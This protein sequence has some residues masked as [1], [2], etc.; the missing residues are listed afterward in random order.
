MKEVLL[1]A[2]HIKTVIIC[3]LSALVAV[4]FAF[5]FVPQLI[6][7][8]EYV[9]I[10][11]TALG[12]PG[13]EN[14]EGSASVYIF[15]IF[16]DNQPIDLEAVPLGEGWMYEDIY[17]G[18]LLAY[19]Q[20]SVLELLLPPGNLSIEFHQHA[21]SGWVRIEGAGDSLEYDLFSLEP[22]SLTHA[23]T[24]LEVTYSH[25]AVLLI[26]VIAYIAALV[27][28]LSIRHLPARANILT[29]I[30]SVFLIIVFV[31]AANP[32]P[33]VFANDE[34]LLNAVNSRNLGTTVSF[35][36]TEHFHTEGITVTITTSSP[37][38]Q[39]FYTIDGSVP[40]IYSAEYSH[41]LHFELRPELYA[42]VLRAVAMVDGVTTK[43]FTQT[44]FI[45]E[46][47]RE[48]FETLVFSLSTDPDNLFGHEYGIL[49]EGQMREE[50][51]RKNPH[52]EVEFMSP[53]NFFM[54]GI[55]WERPVHVEVFDEMER[56]FYQDA[57]VRIHGSSSRGLPQKSLRLMARRMYSYE[58]GWFD[59]DFFPSFISYDNSPVVRTNTLLL[60][61]L[62]GGGGGIF[63]QEI[64]LRLAERAG[65]IATPVRVAS[66]FINGDYYGAMW[67]QSR[68]DA[69]F[70]SEV[71]N[72]PTRDFDIVNLYGRRSYYL[73]F[74][75][76]EHL[77]NDLLAI[78]DFSL[79]NLH[80]DI[81][82]MNLRQIIDIDNL[83]LY[84][85]FNIFVGNDDLQAHNTRR[86][87]YTGKPVNG[88]LELD[89]RWRY[90][91][92]DL[93]AT[94]NAST[95]PWSNGNTF[96]SVLVGYDTEHPM[97]QDILSED[98]LAERFRTTTQL[99]ENRG[100]L[101]AN[102]LT[103]SDMADYFTLIMCDLASNVINRE[104][105]DVILSELFYDNTWNEIY[106]WAERWNGE[107]VCVDTIRTKHQ[108]TRN[109]VTSRHEY[110]FQS[111]SDYFGFPLDMF[112]VRVIGGEAIIGTQRGIA[113]K[114]F[115]HLTIPISPVLPKF[116][117]FSHWVLNGS[118]IYTPNI[119]VAFEDAVNGYVKL[120]LV[121]EPAIPPLAIYSANESELGNGSILIN[122]SN[123]S[124]RTDG[125]YL[126]NDSKNLQLWKLPAASVSPG[127]TLQ[128]TGNSSIDFTHRFRI[129]K[130]FN[131]QNGEILFLSDEHG[132]ILDS[133]PIRPDAQ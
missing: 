40:N 75:D 26:L 15:N 24:A 70:L 12:E 18:V 56:V 80:D 61:R 84:Y 118:N 126:S 41:P 100:Q 31:F 130:G 98:E 74:E 113:S 57:G 88:V 128:L 112:T 48:R 104:T 92:F 89:G 72:T 96:H 106:H 58:T 87:R 10:T 76:N 54:R 6:V 20:P 68:V 39:I 83:L 1:D 36:K 125:L 14:P 47:T 131:I 114:Y 38:A 27:F 97:L 66:V 101:L 3:G 59:F 53:A 2:I 64:G 86:W 71:F 82:F 107:V 123:S 65:L 55:E 69:H 30:S 115:N 81:A 119:T 105:V 95:L 129:R 5:V 22:T 34:L 103:R 108:I 49:V 13:V 120:E 79:K 127:A 111:L 8:N 51:I 9:E 23:F 133:I 93:D 90:A 77:A 91:V 19:I 99:M 94:L 37:Y 116:T 78:E 46:N 33:G 132:N 7:S 28:T 102:I 11:L 21:W 4:I 29:F 45:G 43:P 60:R 32:L 85:A 67:L 110:I 62:Q 50:F 17:G 124:V 42:I 35:S 109:F 121:T 16:V 52:I 117:A 63:R 73:L 25:N 44:Y 122:L